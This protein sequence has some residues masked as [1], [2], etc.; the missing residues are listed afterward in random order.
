MKMR[1]A[2]AVL[3]P[4]L[5]LALQ[6]GL[7]STLAPFVWFLFFPAVFFSA[8]IGGLWGGLI[9]TVVSTLIVWYFF[10]PPQLSWKLDNPGNVYSV[11]LFLLM[12]YLFSDSQE[13]LRRARLKTDASLAESRAANDKINQLYLKTLELDQLKSSFFANVSH[14]L[15]TPLTLIMSPLAQRLATKD[16][17]EA[18]RR[19][20]EMMLRNARM[21]YRQVSDLLDAAKLESGRMRVN[22]ARLDIGG[23]TRATA[24]QFDSLAQEK[25]IEYR[26]EVA[27]PLHAE[28]D[29][30]MIQRILLNLLSNAFKFTP[31]GGCIGVSLRREADA[32]E[33]AIQDNGPGIPDNMREAIFERFRQ[34]EDSARRRYGGT[35]LGLAIVKDFAEL[36]G[37]SASV[38]KVQ[39]GGSRF[40]VRLPLRAPSD[41]II[42]DTTTQL[43][44][45]LDGLT[46]AELSTPTRSSEIPP[47]YSAAANAPLVLVIEDNADMNEFIA[48]TL[49]PHYRVVSAV[50][51]QEG[52]A[53]ALALQPDLI[54]S[55][56]MMPLMSGDQLVIELRRE[57]RTGDIPIIILSAKTDE[58]LRVSLFEQG[59]QG[60]LNK[61]FSTE[62]LLARV[63][64][65]MATRRHT[66]EEL[67]R[68]ELALTNAQQLA[69]VGSWT[70]DLRADRPTWSAEMYR[71]FGLEPAL[72]PPRYNDTSHFL[73]PDSRAHLAAAREKLATQGIPYQCEAEVLRPD[74]SQVWVISHGEAILNATGIVVGVHGTVHNITER[75]RAENALW[76]QT[77]SLK[78][79][80]EE[81]ERFNRAAVK[82]ELEMIRLKQQVNALSIQVGEQ[83]PYPLAFVG[84]PGLGDGSAKP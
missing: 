20:D 62:E 37:G 44:P 22:Y 78:R 81:L 36:H 15:R 39:D 2:I 11:L 12:G 59:I 35:G 25:R 16:L 75:K 17:T 46:V 66:L 4:F 38:V 43:D 40:V 64:G 47:G 54:I 50:D 73:A 68:S 53:K 57:P 83:A 55:D 13:R 14:E 33:I 80:N 65:L 56:I 42:H 49:R 7:W 84:E 23:L 71:I 28:A 26:V 70:W 79:R 74:G 67:T 76:S 10:I 30:E 8:R 60:Y 19:A 3:L 32:A 27:A 9:S 1:V 63:G 72:P 41:A 6:W 61:P 52:L 45:I 51:G 29:G 18:I 69:G 82:R 77:E 5:A 34:V 21:L 31:E 24:A 48:T 58:G